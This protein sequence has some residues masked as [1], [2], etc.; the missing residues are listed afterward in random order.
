LRGEEKAVFRF[1]GSAIVVFDEAGKWWPSADLLEH[2][3]DKA[4]TL[5]RLGDC[6]A[7]AGAQQIA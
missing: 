7:I 6:V 1:G 5:V 4:E 3:R 2:N